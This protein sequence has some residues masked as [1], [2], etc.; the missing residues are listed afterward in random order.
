MLTSCTRNLKIYNY[1]Y[2]KEFK[3]IV[4]AAV[5]SLTTKACCS[6]MVANAFSM[7]ILTKVDTEF[8]DDFQ[9][10]YNIAVDRFIALRDNSTITVFTLKGAFKQLCT[11]SSSFQITTLSLV[12]Q[13]NLLVI[14]GYAS[15]VVLWDLSDTSQKYE[16]SI[17]PFQW[18][19]NLLVLERRKLLAL[20]THKSVLFVDY[21]SKTMKFMIEDKFEIGSLLLYSEKY[22]LF[23]GHHYVY[24]DTGT[25]ENTI[26][27]LFVNKT[28][29]SPDEIVFH[30]GCSKE[31]TIDNLRPR[32]E[33][34]TLWKHNERENVFLKKITL[35]SQY[36]VSFIY[37]EGGE[38]FGLYDREKK[39]I[40]IQNL[41]DVRK[42]FKVYYGTSKMVDRIQLLHNDHNRVI[43][44]ARMQ[45]ANVGVINIKLNTR[46]LEN[47]KQGS[48]P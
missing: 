10:C 35:E 20:K 4:L 37:D 45:R 22:D 12:K 48:D 36:N 46:L 18:A 28:I 40:L 30:T 15:K 43:L 21:I 41:A 16:V 31:I 23:I 7:K 8:N 38:N 39:T 26:K 24:D 42:F 6:L 34:F 17:A 33:I 19:H 2:I 25:N 29:S 14:A 3:L 32:L 13:E 9:S 1:Q 27:P 5:N 47:R 11:L 44:L